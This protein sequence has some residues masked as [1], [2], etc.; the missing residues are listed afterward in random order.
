MSLDNDFLN[1]FD[2]TP[3]FNLFHR[4]FKHRVKKILIV[5]SWYDRFLLE[6]DG[7]LSDQLID[8]FISLNLSS[9]PEII[10]VSSSLRALELLKD[11]DFDL[12]ITM[13]RIGDLDPFAFGKKAK[14]LTTKTPVVLLLSNSIELKGL[15]PRHLQEGIDRIFL[16]NGDSRIFLAIIKLFE[17]EKN[18]DHD[19]K[20]GKIQVILLVENDVRYYSIFL[21]MLYTQVM[22]QT[23]R[24][25]E[26]DALN[27]SHRLLR[28][29]A[30]PKIL[31]TETY[32][33]G[34][35][36]F[37]K[38]KTSLLGVF[39]DVAFPR[40]KSSEID[41]N[42]GTDFIQNVKS[43]DSM[44][45]TLLMSSQLENLKKAEDL[46][47]SFIF[48][49]SPKM[50]HF[51][52]KFIS[53]SMG[54][55]EFIF[56]LPN[57]TEVGRA[58]N[59]EELKNQIKNVPEESLLFHAT[60]N[61]FSA[62]LMARGEFDLAYKLR[63]LTLDDFNR[64]IYD[65]RI[66][67]IEIIDQ[68]K[69]ETQSG[70][71]VNF[72]SHSSKTFFFN[73]S[74][75]GGGSL[76]GKGRG[77]AFLHNLLSKSGIGEKYSEIQIRI[78]YTV[79]ICTDE[80]DKF[81][82]VNN[83]HDVL[84]P[85]YSEEQ[86][87]EL[88]V[89]AKL[90]K[91]LKSKLMLF[92]SQINV[93][94]AVRSSSLLED[95]QFQSLAGIYQTYMLPNNHSDP[96]IRLDNLCIAIKL[97]YASVFSELAKNYISN[98]GQKIEQEKMAVILQEIVGQDHN[99]RFYPD[100]SG[101]A[102]SFNF[103]PYG[104]Q[105]AEDGIAYIALGLGKTIERG[106]PLRFSPKEPQILPQL[107]T[108]KQ[109]IENSQSEFYVLDLQNDNFEL[110]K[111]E[112]AT[113]KS[114]TLKEAEDDG[115]L[116][117]IGGVYDPESNVIRDGLSWNGPR[118]I[119]FASILKPPSIFPLAEI[120]ADFLAI[121]WKA[122]GIPVE[123]EFAVNLASGKKRGE[124]CLLQI[125]PFVIEGGIYRRVMIDKPINYS[126]TLIYSSQAL[127]HGSINNIQNIIYVKPKAFNR[128]KTLEI[129]SEI[130]KL[131]KKLKLEETQYLLIGYGRWGSNDYSLGI[132]V[133]WGDI[134]EASV[135]VEAGL[136]DYNIDPSFGTH[137]FAKL[138]ESNL[139]YFT[140][141]PT[142][143]KDFIN[144][145]WF[146]N[147]KIIEETTYLTHIKLENPLEIIIDGKK[148]EGIIK[149]PNLTEKDVS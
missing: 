122:F 45:P 70:T 40:T 95:S 107:S 65:L 119:T 59:L 104:R 43:Y 117:K 73:F 96:N 100:I 110:Q 4:L 38:Y 25:I 143:T 81:I 127:G 115:V 90:P 68:L 88:F 34:M 120:L 109:I 7:R 130:S 33:E 138:T 8:E 124:F 123:L 58:D 111:G 52:K 113:L 42:S 93:P 32:E 118:V 60:R 126:E 145:K 19:T 134:S 62:W 92:L 11:Q 85:S 2:Y 61:H 147:S 101:G 128:L 72:T 133:N 91:N 94:I 17:D 116:Y 37:E 139:P 64:S 86:I 36:Y 137:F 78:P 21:P 1:N 46:D 83:L 79:V 142:S 136:E 10:G 80:F 44:I 129:A 12:I 51:L 39:S 27:E 66:Y 84:S 57:G 13:S 53:D 14:K 102:Q 50:G 16:W 9:P 28:M 77:L 114:F 132:P 103:Y 144:N 35:K 48:K 71:V 18:I 41:P 24:L 141:S 125:R 26:T 87:N 112:E 69:K 75:I 22:K 108:T 148:R 6:E 149:L 49:N 3:R 140:I 55:G 63:P 20:V 99:D 67:L 30:R 5:S 135:I 29:R 31:F 97:V 54:F 23:Q 82:E 56:R 76:G 121:G 47:S 98:I 105:K 146:E 89:S 131:N 106:M 74:K 15:P